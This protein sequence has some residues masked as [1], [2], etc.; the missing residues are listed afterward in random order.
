MDISV[1]SGKLREEPDVDERPKTGI[2]ADD[3]PKEDIEASRKRMRFNAL[4]LLLIFVL[5][6]VTPYPWNSYAPL[7][8]LIPAVY[9]LVTRFRKVG[10]LKRAPEEAGSRHDAFSVDEPYAI[11]PKGKDD[12]RKYRPIG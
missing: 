6:I 4:V 1:Y 10:H 5:S 7:L 12:P 2:D 8:I 11:E 9:A 3:L